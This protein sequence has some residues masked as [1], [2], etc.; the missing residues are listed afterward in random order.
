[1]FRFA[2]LS[3]ITSYE[4]HFLGVEKIIGWAISYHF[5]HSS[6][7]SI[8]DSKLVISAK[9]LCLSFLGMLIISTLKI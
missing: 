1:M 9:R 7:A 5:M 6:K 3:L 8:K 4:L 2:A